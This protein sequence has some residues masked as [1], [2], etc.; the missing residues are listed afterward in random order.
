MFLPK[1]VYE[2]LPCVYVVAGIVCLYLVSGVTLVPALMK[3][4]SVLLFASGVI[5]GAAGIA[6]I[7]LRYT[8][9]KNE[10]VF[11]KYTAEHPGDV[12]PSE[13]E[14][15]SRPEVSPAHK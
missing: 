1:P 11:V 13:T 3:L 7:S 2:A 15:R 6:I 4:E 14:G 10:T 8:Y 12:N 9:R 5:L